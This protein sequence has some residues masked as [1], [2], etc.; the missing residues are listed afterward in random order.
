M[1]IVVHYPEDRQGI[2][3][4]RKAVAETHSEY[5]YSY[6]ERLQC[7]Q[8]QKKMIHLFSHLQKMLT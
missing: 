6:I 2:S 1:E 8:E 4:L 3:T 5:I 7:S